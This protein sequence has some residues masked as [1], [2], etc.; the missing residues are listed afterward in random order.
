M[1]S[2]DE[3]GDLFTLG[4]DGALDGFTD[5][6]DLFQVH[7]TQPS[8]MAASCETLAAVELTL[9]SVKCFTA[10]WH[11]NTASEALSVFVWSV[12]WMCELFRW[13]RSVQGEGK[14][15]APQGEQRG[16]RRR[17]SARASG[18]QGKNAQKSGSRR[19]KSEALR[20]RKCSNSSSLLGTKTVSLEPEGGDGENKSSAE[21]DESGADSKGDDNAVLQALYDGAPLSSVFHH[22]L[23]EGV[24]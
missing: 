8:K 21:V 20:Q 22:D 15:D 10:P 7:L 1:F 14:V 23:A 2:A 5:T 24:W 18:V 16:A 4:D 6:V 9:V 11:K 12:W 19:G 3:L 13:F 17:H